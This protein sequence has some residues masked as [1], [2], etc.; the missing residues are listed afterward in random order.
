MESI[1]A[2]MPETKFVSLWTPCGTQYLE[3][4]SLLPYR[5][6][7]DSLR[8]RS[9]LQPIKRFRCLVKDL[10]W[11][12][13]GNLAFIALQNIVTKMADDPLCWGNISEAISCSPYGD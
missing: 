3:Q 11:Q 5:F 1:A 4:K 12:L 10:I 9:T 13:Q 2:T 6:Q 7:Q 8:I